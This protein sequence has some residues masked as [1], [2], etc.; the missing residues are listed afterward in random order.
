MDK[1]FI[2]RT[3]E[4]LTQRFNQQFP[5]NPVTL[6]SHD[7]GDNFTIQAHERRLSGVLVQDIATAASLLNFSFGVYVNEDGLY[8]L[9]S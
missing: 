6:T 8:I 9:V 2:K 7:N 3:L 1:K 5:Y 4:A